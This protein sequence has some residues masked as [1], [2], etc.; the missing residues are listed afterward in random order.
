MENEMSGARGTYGAQDRSIQGLGGGNLMEK[1]PLGRPRC[2]WEDNIE[3]DIQE[4][5]WGVVD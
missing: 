1:S 2:R 3:I 4:M 5:G